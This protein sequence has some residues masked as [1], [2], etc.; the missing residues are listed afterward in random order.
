[1]VCHAHGITCM[2][3]TIS[4]AVDQSTGCFLSVDDAENRNDCGLTMLKAWL[5]TKKGN[6]KKVERNIIL[7][8]IRRGQI[9]TDFGEKKKKKIQAEE[10]KFDVCHQPMTDIAEDIRQFRLQLAPPKQTART[11]LI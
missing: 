9:D 11:F 10:R 6:Y 8:R 3:T 7:E 2:R 4:V 1:M 5:C